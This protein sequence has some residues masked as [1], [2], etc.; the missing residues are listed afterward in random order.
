MAT[1]GRPARR[2]LAPLPTPS[3]PRGCS[4]RTFC[5]L[6]P[7][8]LRC[9]NQAASAPEDL[10]Q[11]SRAAGQGRDA[12]CSRPPD[13]RQP[14]RTF[15]GVRPPVPPTAAD[16]SQPLSSCQLKL[17]CPLIYAFCTPCKCVPRPSGG[18]H[19]VLAPPGAPSAQPPRAFDAVQPHA[20]LLLLPTCCLLSAALQ[21]S[22]GAANIT[23]S[24][25]EQSPAVW[26]GHPPARR[27]RR[28][29]RRP[30]PAAAK[31]DGGARQG[32]AP[33]SGPLLGSAERR[34]GRCA[35]GW[36]PPGTRSA[37]RL[38]RPACEPPK[39]IPDLIISV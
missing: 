22:I 11:H 37:Q 20:L 28:R 5:P 7:G 9:S 34:A 3:D 18:V 2:L 1:A 12:C 19:H 13:R 32:R 36:A 16:R 10:R 31:S 29:R 14:P 27:R 30:P 25:V 4:T 17:R 26:E 38:P 23:T 21:L 39:P 24:S 6:L 8:L 35:A 33:A 15:G